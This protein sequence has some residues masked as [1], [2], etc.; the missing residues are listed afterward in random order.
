MFDIMTK[1]NRGEQ[2][3]DV[4]IGVRISSDMH[5]QLMKQAIRQR[6]P[7]SEAVRELLQ[8]SLEA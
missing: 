1:R 6:K 8:R 3:R 7:L 5:K 4:R 2:A